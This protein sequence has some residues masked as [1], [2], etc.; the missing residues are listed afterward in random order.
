MKQIKPNYFHQHFIYK[1][2]C[3][4]I[5][6]SAETK[7]SPITKVEEVCENDAYSVWHK[8][9]DIDQRRHKWRYADALMV[10]ADACKNTM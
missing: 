7:P 6:S 3:S 1:S 10:F 8:V 5:L 9:V 2:L 4:K